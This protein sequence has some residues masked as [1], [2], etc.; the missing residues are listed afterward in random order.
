MGGTYEFTKNA[1]ANLREKDDS[2]NEAIGGFL[3]GSVLGLR[4]GTTPAVL[5]FGALTGVVLSAFSYTGGTL[6]GFRQDHTLDEFERKEFLR[7]NRRVPIEQT[8]AELGEGRGIYGSGYDERRRER[9]K[10]RYGIDMVPTRSDAYVKPSGTFVQE[11]ISQLQ[12]FSTGGERLD[13]VEYCLASITTLSKAVASA[14]DFIPAYDQR[15]YSQAIKALSENL[16]EA[17]S[18]IAPK[19]RFRFK[20]TNK[21]G[22]GI[23]INDAVELAVQKR[24]DADAKLSVA[25]STE[26]SMATTP[27]NLMTPSVDESAVDVVG[28]LPSFP[29]NYNKEM[30][31]A[32]G[33]VR[34][35]SFSQA[36][37]INITGHTGLHI[38]L[39]SS[40]SR[41]TSSGAVTKLDRCILDMSVPTINGAPFAGLALKNIKQSLILAGHVDGPAHITGVENSIIVVASR[42]VRMHECKN[43][44]IYLHC[45]SRPII[46]DCSNIRFA[47]APESHTIPG[48]SVQ[49][50][51]DQVDDFKWLKAEHSPNWSVLPEEER[52]PDSIWTS[53]VPGGPGVGL[54]DILKKVGI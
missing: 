17:R 36:N 53:V 22:S 54:D 11:Q 52:L 21:N 25:S 32:S 16:E 10:E 27:A 42:Q 35:P 44:D 7:K 34:K 38:I 50:Q 29:K 5:G 2:Y 6:A 12:N 8:V 20:N 33:P 30:S 13:A 3:A 14:T 4:F 19:A 28:D 37:S 45:A 43:V 48:N 47:P 24:L 49:N 39:P 18:K 15:A 1:S 23:S 31:S 26:S 46:E 51:W 41:A 9:I 40:A